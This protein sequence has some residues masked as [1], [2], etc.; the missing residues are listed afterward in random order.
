MYKSL[1]WVSR[2]MMLYFL[3]YLFSIGYRT[4]QTKELLKEEKKLKNQKHTYIIL[5]P[6][7]IIVQVRSIPY[8]SNKR[9]EHYRIWKASFTA[10]VH[11]KGS[12]PSV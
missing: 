11:R 2:H 1:T 12:T 6:S 4:F 5:F 7:L 3:F 8:I 9:T 10:H